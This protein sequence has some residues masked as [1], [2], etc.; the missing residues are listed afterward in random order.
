MAEE[1]EIKEEELGSQL[2]MPVLTEEAEREIG[3]EDYTGAATLA[4]AEEEAP[5]E[6]DL[7][8]VLKSLTPKYK[9]KRMNELLQPIPVS[10]IFPDNYLDLNYLLVMSMIEEQEG[11]DD[12]DFAAIVTGVQASTS[13][14]YEG[15]GIADRLEIA[16]VAHEE[17]LEK[18]TKEL[19]L[20][21]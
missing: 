13:I 17:E 6:S 20:G 11:E 15:R 3:L 8:A 4:E 21:G 16:G 18:L 19:G 2:D 9:S 1:D 7:K 12:I 5:H 10:R 14:G